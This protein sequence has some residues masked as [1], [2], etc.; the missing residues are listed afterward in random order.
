MKDV[1]D[2]GKKKDKTEQELAKLVQ[3]IQ[4]QDEL[5]QQAQSGLTRLK[6][7]PN[8]DSVKSFFSASDFSA[9]IIGKFADASPALLEVIGG[10]RNE[11]QYLLK[12]SGSDTTKLKVIK[13]AMDNLLGY[14]KDVQKE[15]LKLDAKLKAMQD[16]VRPTCRC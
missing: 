16:P 7:P 5:Q 12:K 13:N 2:A 3:K 8:L 15:I 11:M 4:A 14:K 1:E 6:S 9:Q 10:I